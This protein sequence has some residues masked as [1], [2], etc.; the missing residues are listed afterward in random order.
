MHTMA[1]SKVNRYGRNDWVERR[2]KGRGSAYLFGSLGVDAH[3][4]IQFSAGYEMIDFYHGSIRLHHCLSL[5]KKQTELI[6]KMSV[7]LHKTV[8]RLEKFSGPP[9]V[10][11]K[12][13]CLLC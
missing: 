5:R 7:E 4:L 2:M 11:K 12:W 8:L 6:Y 10:L 9:V 13:A 3:E 1:L